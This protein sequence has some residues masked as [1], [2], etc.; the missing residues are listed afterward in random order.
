MLEAL[1]AVV[2][3]CEREIESQILR[4][5]EVDTQTDTQIPVD[6]HRQTDRFCIYPEVAIGMTSSTVPPFLFLDK[7][8]H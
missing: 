4:Q 2:C 6:R 8:S 5:T 3:V 7:V 1:C